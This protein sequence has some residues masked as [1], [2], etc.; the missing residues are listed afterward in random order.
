MLDE[1]DKAIVKV[2][3]HELLNEKV[4][5]R[6]NCITRHEAIANQF[7]MNDRA[8]KIQTNEFERRLDDLNGEANRLRSIH[9]TYLP[10]EVYENDIRQIREDI[11]S[12]ISFKDNLIGRMIVTAGIVAI[13]ASIFTSVLWKLVSSVR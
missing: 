10:R 7:K 6:D 13:V 1:A 3:A 9:T 11:K 12:L 2:I 8:L 4:V 5:Y